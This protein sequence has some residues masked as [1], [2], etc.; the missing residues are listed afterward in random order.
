MSENKKDE[1]SLTESQENVEHFDDIKI[2]D[3]ITDP[4]QIIDE[5]REILEKEK[6]KS[7]RLRQIIKI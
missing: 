3:G 5:L 1:N 4:S 7:L 6:E 2:C